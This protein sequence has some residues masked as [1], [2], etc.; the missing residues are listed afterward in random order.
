ME[1]KVLHFLE[2]MVVSRV[3]ILNIFLLFYMKNIS[4][5]HWEPKLIQIILESRSHI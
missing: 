1:I 4:V 2:N 5:G 3:G